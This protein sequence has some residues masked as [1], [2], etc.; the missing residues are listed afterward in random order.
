[1]VLAG[2]CLE[3]SAIPSVLALI[4]ELSI[5]GSMGYGEAEYI[6]ALSMMADPDLNLRRLHK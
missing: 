5:V 2:V 1:M 3:D 6:T 4:H